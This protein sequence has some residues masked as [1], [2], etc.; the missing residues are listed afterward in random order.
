[1]TELTQTK[2]RLG[3]LVVFT[4]NMVFQTGFENSTGNTKFGPS[5]GIKLERLKFCTS[6]DWKQTVINWSVLPGKE[7]KWKEKSRAIKEMSGLWVLCLRHLLLE[8][9]YRPESAESVDLSHYV[10]RSQVHFWWPMKDGI[11]VNRY[12]SNSSRLNMHFD[13]QIMQS[14]I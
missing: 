1:M 5:I 3:I 10:R 14:F 13:N 7:R 6:N 11:N 4:H 12:R 9:R 2:Y 8:C